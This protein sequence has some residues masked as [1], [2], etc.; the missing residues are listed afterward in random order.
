V[1]QNPDAVPHNW[2]LVEPGRLAV[3]G[4]LCNRM[5]GTADALVRQYVP[6][7]DDV[8]VYSNLTQPQKSAAVFFKAPEKSGVYPFLCTFPGHWMVMNGELEVVN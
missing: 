2:V 6:E 7:S 3:I 8:L 4:D 5:V 1:F